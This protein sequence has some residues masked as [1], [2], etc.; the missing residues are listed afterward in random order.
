VPNTTWVGRSRARWPSEVLQWAGDPAATPFEEAGQ[1]RAALRRR[2]RPIG[3]FDVLLA[4]CALARGLT[5]VT[6]NVDELA[7]IDGLSVENWR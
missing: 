5:L 6:A 4:G 3:P 2:G 7:R 1:V